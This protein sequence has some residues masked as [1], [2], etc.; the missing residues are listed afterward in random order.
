MFDSK[1]ISGLRLIRGIFSRQSSTEK[2]FRVDQKLYKE[3]NLGQDCAKKV[4]RNFCK[5]D[6]RSFK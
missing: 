4:N 1:H 3:T 6:R 2:N 5:F